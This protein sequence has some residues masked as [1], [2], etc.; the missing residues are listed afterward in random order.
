MDA[1]QAGYKGTALKNFY[2]DLQR[3]FLSIPGVRN[4]TLTDMPLVA[5]WTST[6]SVKMPGLSETDKEDRRVAVTQVG[7]GFFETMGIPILAGR[8]IDER[9]RE[10]APAVAVVNQVFVKKFF[11]GISPM[12]RHFRLQMEKDPPDLEVVG[13]ARSARQS[14]LKGEIPPVAYVSYLQAD[15]NHPLQMFFELRTT[16]NP[17][18]LANTVRRIVHEAGPEVP[19]ADLTTQS[20]VIDETIVQE[21]TFAAL[22]SC[23]GVLA[24]VMACVGLYASMAYA[25]AR[26]TGEIGIRM[27]LGAVRSRIIWM[28]ISEVLAVAAVGLVIGLTAV[29]EVTGFLQSFLYDLKPHDPVTF[30]AAVFILMLCTILAGYAPAWRASRIDPMVALRH[31]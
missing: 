16:G 15:K 31:E 3:R 30:G 2:S 10:N 4:A 20:R 1:A 6:T 24:L 7:P 14:S 18:A 17:L 12:G 27:A 13:V 29:W 8:S 19:V 9:D 23:F 5:D 22:C 25:V 21:R 11:S 28:V 26:R